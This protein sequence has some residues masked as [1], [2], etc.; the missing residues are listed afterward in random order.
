M[1]GLILAA[2]VFG[3]SI[4]A[5]ASDSPKGGG[6]PVKTK[7]PYAGRP[8]QD[9]YAAGAALAT[10]APEREGALSVKWSVPSPPGATQSL[11][12]R[13]VT[14]SGVY[15]AT[16]LGL[17]KHASAD[18]AARALP[19]P[20]DESQ[21]LG[22]STEPNG[23]VGVVAWQAES[24][25]YVSVIDLE[26]DRIRFSTPFTATYGYSQFVYVA[27][28]SSAVFAV[29]GA[30]VHAFDLRDGRLLWTWDAGSLG[31]ASLSIGGLL[32]DDKTVLLS[33]EERDKLAGVG[34]ALNAADGAMIWNA[35]LTDHQIRYASVVNVD[36]PTFLVTAEGDLRRTL[37]VTDER[38]VLLNLV[39]AEPG[40][41]GFGLETT[42][43]GD[44]THE[45]PL[46]VVDG[47]FY[48]RD[49]FGREGKGVTAVDLRTGEAKWRTPMPAP[50]EELLITTDLHVAGSAPG[51]VFVVATESYEESRGVVVWRVS[52]TDGAWTK[53][54]EGPPVP[55]EFDSTEPW[56]TWSGQDL[57]AIKEL[58]RHLVVKIAI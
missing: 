16:K 42:R 4:L 30:L 13:W 36:P 29:A 54:A 32:A 37:V 34:I 43:I 21:I 31:R 51:A 48:T 28:N 27:A 58:A 44:R 41:P 39:S 14:D 40:E 12:G 15:L 49:E 25:K 45:L 26:T 24:G 23:S 35:T 2:S 3:C 7:D 19:M 8:G 11:L 46:L 50:P 47:V 6:S 1:L 38:G 33:A 20:E 57:Y 55:A 52:T 17:V 10:S 22:M 18:G 9:A 5:G 56:F 53:H